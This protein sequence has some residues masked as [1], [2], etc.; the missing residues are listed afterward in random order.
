MR[1]RFNGPLD[2]PFGVLAAA[3]PFAFY[4][5][6]GERSSDLVELYELELP[7]AA[8]AGRMLVNEGA[9]E[10]AAAGSSLPA[11]LPS[12]WSALTAEDLT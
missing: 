11:L 7:A 3:L 1:A 9:R 12:F 4:L 2:G 10:K 5:D 6:E 8:A